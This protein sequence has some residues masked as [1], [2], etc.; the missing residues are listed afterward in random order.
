MPDTAETL[1]ANLGETYVASISSPSPRHPAAMGWRAHTSTMAAGFT[2]ALHS[3]HQIAPDQA[4]DIA[5]WFAGPLDDGPD[6]EEHM[7]WVA[8][9][10]A[11]H[12]DTFQKW[13]AEGRTAA[14][15]A[16]QFT[17]EWERKQREASA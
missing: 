1:L 16:Q 3:L 10:I 17:A 14:E 6:P 4:A 15:R 12:P 7:D 2:R 13:L 5:T 8:E 9:H 11:A